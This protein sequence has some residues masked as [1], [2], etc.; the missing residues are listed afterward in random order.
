MFLKVGQINRDTCGW[1]VDIWAKHNGVTTVRVAY[2]VGRWKKE[3][4]SHE[5]SMSEPFIWSHV[6]IPWPIVTRTAPKWTYLMVTLVAKWVGWVPATYHPDSL[7]VTVFV[8]QTASCGWLRFIYSL[9]KGTMRVCNTSELSSA[10]LSFL[11]LNRTNSFFPVRNWR[12]LFFPEWVKKKKTD[13][14]DFY[15]LF[16]VLSNR[17]FLSSL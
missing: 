13:S 14:N 1:Q 4:N 15:R 3:P 6:V 5:V 8:P 9:P 7:H 17:V 11:Y 12:Q 10:L 2:S 16:G